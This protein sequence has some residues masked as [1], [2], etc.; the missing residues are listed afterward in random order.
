MDNKKSVSRSM[1]VIVTAVVI[2]LALV[3]SY[4]AASAAVSKAYSQIFEQNLLNAEEVINE[5]DSSSAR[6]NYEFSNQI[7]SKATIVSKDI[8]EDATNEYLQILAEDNKLDAV[9]VTDRKGNIVKSYPEQ[10]SGAKLSDNDETIELTKVARGNSAKMHT[11]PQPADVIGDE[12]SLYAAVPRTDAE[13]AVVV[14]LTVDNYDEVTGANLAE[15]C[16][17]GIFI[18]KNGECLSYNA[19]FNFDFINLEN[20]GVTEADLNNGSFALNVKN[21]ENFVCRGKIIGDYTV[22]CAVKDGGEMSLVLWVM[23]ITGIILLVVAVAVFLLTDFMKQFFDIKFWKFIMVGILNTV[24]GMGLQF[25][26]FNLCGWGEWIS[27][28]VGYILGSILSYFLNKYFTFKNK[29]KG[30]KPIAKFALNIAVCYGLA[31]GIAIPL[32]KWICVANSLTM[33]GWTV[34]KFAGNVSMLVGSCLFVAFNYIGQRFF[35]FKEKK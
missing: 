30:W 14:K 34:D 9:Y 26:F 3:V 22:V 21:D 31:Y 10:T 25:L 13:G 32:T 12:Y 11:E 20:L 27:S 8:F 15:K 2:V 33:F 24:V 5:F 35:A 16:G 7:F 1:A 18:E 28:I 19:D 23:L 29:E 4:F 6:L 17:K